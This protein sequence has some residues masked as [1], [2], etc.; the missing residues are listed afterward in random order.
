MHSVDGNLTDLESRAFLTAKMPKLLSIL[1]NFRTT[2][3][4]TSKHSGGKVPFSELSVWILLIRSV[5]SLTNVGG[6]W[7]RG[8]KL[9]SVKA[10][11]LS[12]AVPQQDVIKRR[13][14]PSL[15]VLTLPNATPGLGSKLAT[16]VAI[17]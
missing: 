11:I 10:E 5:V 17:A 16:Q 9:N 7:V 6:V 15:S 2:S 14:L 8:L 12:I 13:G 4:E 3:Q 1:G